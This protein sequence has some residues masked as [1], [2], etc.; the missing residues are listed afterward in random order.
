[1]GHDADLDGIERWIGLDARDERKST[2]SWR[3]RDRGRPA[4]AS[5]KNGLQAATASLIE[6]EERTADENLR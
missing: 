6:G 5:G 3:T 4:R 2:R 1:V